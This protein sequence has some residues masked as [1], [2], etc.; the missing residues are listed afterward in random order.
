V[1][2]P[3]RSFH[4]V[5]GVTSAAVGGRE[6]TRGPCVFRSH[7]RPTLAPHRP[8]VPRCQRNVNP[9][10]VRSQYANG[11]KRLPP[12]M[13]R[14]G[15]TRLAN[16]FPPPPTTTGQH[17]AQSGGLEVPSSNLGA[18]YD[19]SP[20]AGASVFE[21]RPPSQGLGLTVGTARNRHHFRGRCIARPASQGGEPWLIRFPSVARRR[22]G[23]MSA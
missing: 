13:G 8:D 2:T 10:A 11:L 5:S 6:A 14:T 9:R 21:W 3:T 16:P 4:I 18:R 15:A 20:Q 17:S 23:C 1:A 7:V 19:E 22:A 12:T